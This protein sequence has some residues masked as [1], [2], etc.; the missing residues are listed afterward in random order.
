MRYDELR[1]VNGMMFMLLHKRRLNFIIWPDRDSV[2]MVRHEV[3]VSMFLD[4][5]IQI[6][7]FQPNMNRYATKRHAICGIGLIISVFSL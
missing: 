2:V 4:H 3:Q 5:I 7:Y 1:R 6:C